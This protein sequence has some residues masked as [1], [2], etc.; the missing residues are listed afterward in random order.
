MHSNIHPGAHVDP[1]AIVHPLALV[2]EGSSLSAGVVV[3]AFAA[4][5]GPPQHLGDP[6]LGTTLLVGPRTVIREHV[7][8]NRGSQRG[9]GKTVVG[10]G[11]TFMATSHVGHDC[12]I[13]DEVLLTN[14]AVLAGHCEVGA[15]VILG[16]QSGVH[17][18]TRIGTMA[19]VAG[20]TGVS[21]DVPPYC[22]AAG[23]RARLVGLNEVGLERRGVKKEAISGLRRAYRTVFRSGLLRVD[24]L[25]R[26]REEAEGFSEVSHFID[27]VATASKRGMVRH[28]TS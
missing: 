8:I 22:I 26:A 21:Q 17:Q 23:F 12:M 25:Q 9:G 15:F 4:V 10:A 27:F 11:C 16:G 19:M 14:G 3:H 1:G 20:G 7:T 6:G 18:F 13:G 2:D 28:G 24:A 5:G